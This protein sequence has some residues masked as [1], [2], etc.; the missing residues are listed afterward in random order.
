MTSGARR[1][2][3]AAL[4]GLARGFRTAESLAVAPAPEPGLCQS[5]VHAR[6]VRSARGSLFWL[7][8]VHERDPRFAKYPPLPVRQCDGYAQGRNQEPR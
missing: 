3:G 1:S 2:Q 8:A 4:A 5:C 7:C 6:N